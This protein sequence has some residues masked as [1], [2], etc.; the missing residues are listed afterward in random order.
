MS[1]QSLKQLQTLAKELKIKGYSKLKKDDLYKLIQEHKKSKEKYGI[2]CNALVYHKNK[3]CRCDEYSTEKYCS[4]HRYRYKIEKPSECTICFDALDD[5][6]IPLSCGH[7]FHKECLKPTNVHSCPLCRNNM[8]KNDIKYIF[9]EKHKQKNIYTVNDLVEYGDFVQNGIRNEPEFN[10][11]ELYEPELIQIIELNEIELEHLR[12]L[13]FDLIEYKCQSYDAVNEL[14][15]DQ[16]IIDIF[17]TYENQLVMFRISKI[18]NIKAIIRRSR[19][20][21]R[22]IFNFVNVR[23]FTDLRT[24]FTIIDSLTNNL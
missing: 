13:L 14:N 8:D 23:Y 7:W 5:K 1:S 11:P 12:E 22:P 10:E 9:G 24:I 6:E 21:F 15:I 17:E 4:L 18:H 3:L 19:S 20:S 2:Q 16:M